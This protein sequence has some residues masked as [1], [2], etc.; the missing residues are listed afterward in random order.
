MISKTCEICGLNSCVTW[1]WSKLRWRG[2]NGLLDQSMTLNTSIKLNTC[3]C[4]VGWDLCMSFH[5]IWCSYL[6]F[7]L[8]YYG[9]SYFA[10][11]RIAPWMFI[12][13]FLIKFIYHSRWILWKLYL[14]GWSNLDVSTFYNAPNNFGYISAPPSSCLLYTSD[15][16]DE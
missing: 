4:L 8:L 11:L 15:A 5:M 14:N 10:Q 3:A 9:C 7:Y 13:I 6:H 1:G 2:V 12:A 16:A